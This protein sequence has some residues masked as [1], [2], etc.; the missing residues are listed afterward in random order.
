MSAAIAGVSSTSRPSPMPAHTHSQ[1][2]YQRFIVRLFPARAF[3]RSLSPPLQLYRRAATKE[4]KLVVPA[5]SELPIPGERRDSFSV[6]LLQSC[7]LKRYCKSFAIGRT[8]TKDA[9]EWHRLVP[10]HSDYDWLIFNQSRM[11]KSSGATRIW[12]LRA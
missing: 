9:V 10:H 4:M 3:R 6:L 5:G 7:H 8:N 2:M 11:G 1:D 12:M